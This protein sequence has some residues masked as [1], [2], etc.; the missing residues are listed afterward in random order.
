MICRWNLVRFV[1]SFPFF[2]VLT[3]QFPMGRRAACDI[4]WHGVSFHDN[5]NIVSGQ[6]NKFPGKLHWT[7]G[8]KRINSYQHIQS[9]H[10]NRFPI[11]RLNYLEWAWSYYYQK[12]ILF[13]LWPSSNRTGILHVKILPTDQLSVAVVQWTLI[14]TPR[15]V[16]SHGH[17]LFVSVNT[18]QDLPTVSQW[19]MM[20]CVQ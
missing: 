20:M 15:I 12:P 1:I 7:N 3:S 16:H 5:E 14:Y 4:Y 11:S 18:C 19:C 13:W 8:F 17:L 2:S 10:L 6:V 9:I